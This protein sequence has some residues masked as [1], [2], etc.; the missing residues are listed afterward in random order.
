MIVYFWRVIEFMYI[1]V[2]DEESTDIKRDEIPKSM[3]VP[4]VV[5]GCL[6]FIIGIVWLMEIPLPV[7]DKVNSK[8]GLG[9]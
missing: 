5:L 8:F 4:V 1:K 7:L 9:G 3:L 6:C 2:G